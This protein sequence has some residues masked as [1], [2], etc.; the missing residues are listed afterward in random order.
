[1]F[2]QKTMVLC[3]GSVPCRNELILLGDPLVALVED[4]VAVHVRWL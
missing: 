4:E 2:S 3:I 1:M